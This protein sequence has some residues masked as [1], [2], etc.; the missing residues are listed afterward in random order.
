MDIA[1]GC[2]EA[3]EVYLKSLKGIID[4]IPQ[5]QVWRVIELVCEVGNRGQPIFIMGNGGSAAT[6]SHFANDLNKGARKP[7]K[8]HFK[9]LALTDNAPLITAWANDACYEECFVEQLRNIFVPNSLTIGIS[10]SG[11]SE[12]VIRAIRYA[13]EN[14]GL[15]AALC[16]FDGGRL[17]PLTDCS[18]IVPCD[19][20][21]RIED[22]HM[23]LS[24]L[25]ADVLRDHPERE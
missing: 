3:V 21:G 24:H 22:V 20:M 17:A 11:N 10:A 25:I 18:V 6:A 2:K 15:T 23:I 9:A 1:S 14:G 16:G 7:G 13:S 12:N 4:L 19:H 5:D 8:K